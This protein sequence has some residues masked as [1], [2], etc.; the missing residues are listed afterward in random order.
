M[1]KKILLIVLLCSSIYAK[2]M[3]KNHQGLALSLGLM[4]VGVS[5]FDKARYS[6]VFAGY[7]HYEDSTGSY[8]STFN[9]EH[10]ETVI[11]LHYRQFLRPKIGGWY[12]GGFA[13]YA[14]LEGKLKEE[15]RRATQNKFGIG[16]EIGYSSFGLLGHR[17]FYWQSG[18]GVGVYLDGESEMFEGDE[19]ISDIPVAVHFDLIRIG[20]VF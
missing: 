12:Y 13:K 16:A 15:H 1:I 9:K 17:S 20:F 19:L 6:E 5:Y 3:D 2:P 14:R 11:D 18:F 7:Y 10:S 8:D 4:G